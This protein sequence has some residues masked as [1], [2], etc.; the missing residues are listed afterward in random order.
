MKATGDTLSMYI[1]IPESEISIFKYLAEK[2]GWKIHTS[3]EKEESLN[4][5]EETK[6]FFENSKRSM[7][8]HMEKYILIH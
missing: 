3:K 2:M 5:E 1:D 6:M 4:M 7:A 8:K